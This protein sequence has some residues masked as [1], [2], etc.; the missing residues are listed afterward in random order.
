MNSI[1]KNPRGTHIQYNSN[2][3]NNERRSYDTSMLNINIKNEYIGNNFQSIRD[4]DK[5]ELLII[6][7]IYANN[8]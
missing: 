8:M 2:G 4:L 6:F 3:F 7:Y 5:S 1:C